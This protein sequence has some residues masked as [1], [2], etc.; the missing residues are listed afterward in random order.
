MRCARVLNGEPGWPQRSC[1]VL[2]CVPPCVVPR[3]GRCVGSRGCPTRRFAFRT[4]DQGSSAVPL[5]PRLRARRRGLGPCA[6]ERRRVCSLAGGG[7]D[8]RPTRHR[9]AGR[10]RPVKRGEIWFA[11]TGRGG[12]RPVLVLVLTRDRIGSDRIGSDR[13]RGRGPADDDPLSELALDETDGLRQR[14]VVSFDNLHTP[15]RSAFRRHPNPILPTSTGL[16]REL[17]RR[18]LRRT[19]GFRLDRSGRCPRHRMRV[20]G[21]H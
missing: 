6:A 17:L 13:I 2:G 5:P 12:D 9:L 1:S 7:L 19:A 20:L 11:T 15:P 14:C 10:L 16:R 18:V 21:E 8:R 3:P 4:A